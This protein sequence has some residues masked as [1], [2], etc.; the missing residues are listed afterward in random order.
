[1]PEGAVMPEAAPETPAENLDAI[2]SAEVEALTE[3]VPE[4]IPVEE[5]LPEAPAEEAPVDM[6]VMM[7]AAE[8][9]PAEEP[10]MDMALTE[11]IPALEEPVPEE[12]AEMPALEEPIPDEGP[13]MLALEEPVP[14]E[15]AEEIPAAMDMA[16]VAEAL[17]GAVE[18]IVE[19]LD[20]EDYEYFKTEADG[21]TLILIK[22][23]SG[24]AMAVTY[25]DGE[26]ETLEASYDKDGKTGYSDIMNTFVKDTIKAGGHGQIKR[27]KGSKVVAE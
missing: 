27:H 4:E 1:M 22:T 13:D 17:S 5:P 26:F 7:A 10:A 23:A 6:E 20:G 15:T 3:P 12:M 14:E 2:L 16:Q 25:E 8:A 21:K 24:N 9:A 18:D 19:F 11:E